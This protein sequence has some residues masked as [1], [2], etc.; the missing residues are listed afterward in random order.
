MKTYISY[1]RVS[2]AKQ[3]ASGL[4]LEAQRA[5]VAAYVK[6]TGEIVQEYLEVESGKNNAR[7]VLGKAIAD[8][9]KNGHTLVIAKLDRLSRSVSFLFSLLD[10]KVDFVAADIPTANTLTVGMFATIAQHERE[11]TVARTKAALQAKRERGEPLGNLNNLTDAGRALGRA[12]MQEN[13]RIAEANVQASYLIKLIMQQQQ[14]KPTLRSVAA[15]LNAQGYKTRRGSEFTA[16]QVMR[17]YNQ[18]GAE[19]A[20]ETVAASTYPADLLKNLADTVRNR[21]AITLQ[22]VL[23]ANSWHIDGYDLVLDGVASSDVDVKSH[24]TLLRCTST[25]DVADALERILYPRR[26]YKKHGELQVT[27]EQIDAAFR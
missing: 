23:Q 5:A 16:T 7:P 27:Q 11:T 25:D 10:T 2:T 19:A 9:R 26:W 20:T 22:H 21:T 13:A 17:L 18:V 15:V 1:I 4:G 14:Q 12:V 6:S 24:N 8:S 3:G